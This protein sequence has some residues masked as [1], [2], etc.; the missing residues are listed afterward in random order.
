MAFEVG[1]KQTS[2]GHQTPKKA[3]KMP[4]GSK[5]GPNGVQTALETGVKQGS[6]T[7]ENTVNVENGKS[8]KEGPS[9]P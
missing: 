1:S 4:T 6:N 9:P 7:E 3:A 5:R 2:N 8:S